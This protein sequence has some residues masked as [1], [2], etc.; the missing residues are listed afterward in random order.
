MKACYEVSFPSIESV[1]SKIIDL[2]HVF[3]WCTGGLYGLE[4][5]HTCVMH[6][7]GARAS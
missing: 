5:S 7:V 6:V 4:E 1:Y 3:I 2:V